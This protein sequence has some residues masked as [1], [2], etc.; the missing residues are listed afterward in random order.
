MDRL[1][2]LLVYFLVAC[3]LHYTT[4]ESAFLRAGLKTKFK[5]GDELMKMKFM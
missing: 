3:S 1:L 5:H 4:F 2:F